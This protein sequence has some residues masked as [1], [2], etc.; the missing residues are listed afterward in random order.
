VA[1]KAF[2]ATPVAT[3]AA[4]GEVT[5][6]LATASCPSTEGTAAVIA[7]ASTE[8][9]RSPSVVAMVEVYACEEATGA[10]ARVEAQ[11]PS[12]TAAAAA[13]AGKAIRNPSFVAEVDRNPLGTTAVVAG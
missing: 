2:E 13:A 4:A 9:D 8:V 6:S 10:I 1:S 11:S 3:V 5:S 7:R 12:A